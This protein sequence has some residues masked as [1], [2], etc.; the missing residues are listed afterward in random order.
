MPDPSQTFTTTTDDVDQTLAAAVRHH[1][2]GDGEPMSWSAV[3]QVIHG[4]RVRVNATVCVDDARRLKLG[5]AVEVSATPARVQADVGHAAVRYQDAD[6]VVVE[7][8]AGILTVRNPE[9]AGWDER[10]KMREPTLEELLQRRLPRPPPRKGQPL[11]DWRVR[12]VHRLDRDTSGLMLFALSAAAEQRLIAMFAKHTIERAYRAAVH[13]RLPAPGTYESHFIRDRGDGLRGSTK[14]GAT[15]P[16]TQRAVT[17]V[18]PIAYRG[19]AYTIVECRLETGRTHQIR[20][21]LSEAGHP[22]CGDKV[23]RGHTSRERSKPD[24]SGAPR[25]ALHSARLVFAH[26]V[27]NKVMTFESPWPADLQT[28]WDAL[29]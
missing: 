25:Q 16:D 13:G 19:D 23:Y 11:P 8:P 22:L 14:R 1:L 26:P 7:K 29:H 24:A 3:R 18:E 10:R 15:D 27:S 9:E 12:P 20:I 6:L 5:E 17:H 28:W 2:A 4:R 21:H